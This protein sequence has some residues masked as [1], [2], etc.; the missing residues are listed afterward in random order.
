FSGVEFYL[1]IS[2]LIWV[3]LFGHFLEAKSSAAAGDALEEVA[4]LLPRQ[5]HLFKNGKIED[6]DLSL[7]KEADLVLVKPGEK[8]PADGIIIKGKANID[9]SLI[10]GES[11]PVEKKEGQ[12]VVAGSICLDG[13]LEIKLNRV[14]ENSLIG[15]I[16][17][18]IG[19]AQETKPSAQKLADK[20]A[21]Y[22]TFTALTV[23]IITILVWFLILGKPLVFALTLAITVLVIACPHALGLAIPTVSTIATTLAVKSGLFLK[24]LAKLE[25]VKD[26]DYI[27]LDKTGTLTK[28]EFGVVDIVNSKKQIVKKEILQIAASLEQQSSHFIGQSIVKF[29]KEQN[30]S[31]LAVTNFKNFSGRGVVGRIGGM[32]YW[33]GNETFAEEKS[34]SLAGQE[35]T[36]QGKTVIL[37]GNKKEILGLLAL[38]DKIRP[39]SFRAVSDLHNLGIKVAMLTGDNEQVGK[40]VAKELKIDNFFANVLPEDKYKHIKKLQDEGNRVMM[41]GDGVND[42]PALTQA[43]V[44]VAVGAGTDVA[45]EAGDVVLTRNNPEDI[46]KLV[47]LSKKVFR[48]MQQNLIWATGYNLLAIPAAAGLFSPWGI[49][50]R[51]EIGAI[52]MSLSSVIVVINAITLKKARLSS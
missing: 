18:L 28:G 34:I 19:K 42:A 20:V 3:L 15:Q 14:G 12:E 29:G 1:E 39:E 26:I 7:L 6:V 27:V 48:K 36:S 24:D 10:S 35:L 31:L 38:S 40:A 52:L 44:G 13:S 5:A 43:N 9:E 47:I 23:A 49:F 41:V 11:K 21:S 17:K 2:T 4:K 16:Q 33:L 45:V 46:V 30:V 50:L 22:L 51:P 25:V 37:L 8:M 32:D